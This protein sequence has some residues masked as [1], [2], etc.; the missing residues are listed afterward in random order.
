[1][2]LTQELVQMLAGL[3]YVKASGAGFSGTIRNGEVLFFF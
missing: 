3:P 1:M 2:N